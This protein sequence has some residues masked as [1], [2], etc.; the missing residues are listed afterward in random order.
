MAP[1]VTREVKVSGPGRRGRN[2]CRML[3]VC[4]MCGDA[5]NCWQLAAA[6]RLEA[7]SLSP[8]SI[9]QRLL[10]VDGRWS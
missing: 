3:S 2:R 7:N 10:R 5:M 1:P 9:Q 6:L 8:G 4:G